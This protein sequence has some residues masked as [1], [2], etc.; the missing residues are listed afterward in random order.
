MQSKDSF[1]TIVKPCTYLREWFEA[2]MMRITYWIIF[3]AS[4]KATL[5]SGLE[6]KLAVRRAF[7]TAQLVSDEVCG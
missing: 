3:F 7:L 4:L 6:P 1:L 2:W 5:S